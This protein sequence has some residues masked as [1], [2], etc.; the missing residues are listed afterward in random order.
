MEKADTATLGENDA[1]GGVDYVQKGSEQNRDWD[2]H[3][4]SCRVDE[5]GALSFGNG[6]KNMLQV[7]ASG[8]NPGAVVYVT[9]GP[10]RFERK[11]CSAFEVK[12]AASGNDGSAALICANEDAT[13]H[14]GVR[15]GHCTR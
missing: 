15:F 3:I 7:V 6:S 9:T 14:A 8:K 11:Q 13:L 1:I 2:R 10:V 12:I 5:S 4:T